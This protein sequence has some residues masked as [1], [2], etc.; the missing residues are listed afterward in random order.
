MFRLFKKTNNIC[1]PVSGKCLD[2]SDCS[3]KAFSAMG[4]GFFII[5]STN[6]IKSPCNGEITAIFPTKHAIGITTGQGME[7]LLHIGIDTVKLNGQHMT[8]YVSVGQHVKVG[9]KLVSFD[10]DYMKKQH[11]D[12][13]TIVLVLNG[14]EFTY[15]KKHRNDNV[16][17]GEKIILIESGE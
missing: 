15:T 1:A 9:K 6:V 10:I 8:S 3:D 14:G 4:D 11:I 12:M 5:P 2:I 7:I 17:D 13:S 16:T